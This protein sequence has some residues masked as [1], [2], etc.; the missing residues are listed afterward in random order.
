MNKYIP[1]TDFLRGRATNEIPMTFRE[2]ERIVG[3]T[4]PNSARRHRA[5]WSN[6]TSNSVMTRAWLDA[7]FESSQVDMAGEK[8][9]FR[10]ARGRPGPQ[11][12]PASPAP[13]PISGNA[14]HPLWGALKDMMKVAPGTDLTAPADPDW[15]G[16]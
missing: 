15:G 9:T 3:S 8:L 5:W 16:I 14:D 7:G 10:R 4:L 11:T 1:L 12:A 13:A 2:I 6:N